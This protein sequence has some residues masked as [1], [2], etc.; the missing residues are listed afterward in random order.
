M[1]NKSSSRDF[2][3]TFAVIFLMAG[4][5]PVDAVRRIDSG[6]GCTPVFNHSNISTVEMSCIRNIADRNSIQSSKR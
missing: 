1:K 4:L 5:V 2:G 3:G 6:A